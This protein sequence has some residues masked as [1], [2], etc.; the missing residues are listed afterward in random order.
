[1]FIKKNNVLSTQYL[2]GASLE[3][4]LR[5]KTCNIE[6]IRWSAEQNYERMGTAKEN[7]DVIKTTPKVLK[8]TLTDSQKKSLPRKTQAVAP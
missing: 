7:K 5:S 4:S 6:E 1:M 8:Q 2:E 3:L